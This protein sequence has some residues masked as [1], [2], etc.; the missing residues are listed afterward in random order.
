MDLLILEGLEVTIDL[1]EIAM[2]KGLRMDNPRYIPAMPD[3]GV[4]EQNT[5]PYY[6]KTEIVLKSGEKVVMDVAYA[7]MVNV[8]K[9]WISGQPGP[10]LLQEEEEAEVAPV[11]KTVKKTTKKK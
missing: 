9:T 7:Q 1:A 6:S 8:V 10:E 5:P 11:K 4:P 3:K 2:M